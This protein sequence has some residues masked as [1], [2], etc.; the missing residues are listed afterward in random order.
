MHVE[1]LAE[2][3][4]RHR[5][6]QTQLR[7]VGIVD[8]QRVHELQAR[9][10][11]R[12]VI[13][14]ACTTGQQHGVGEVARR[15]TL[16]L[17]RNNHSMRSNANSSPANVSV[18]WR[19]PWPPHQHRL[20]CSPQAIVRHLLARRLACSVAGSTKSS[21]QTCRGRLSRSSAVGLI[22]GPQRGAIARHVSRSTCRLFVDRAVT[23]S[24]RTCTFA[25]VR[26]LHHRATQVVEERNVAACLEIRTERF[27]DC[28]I[29]FYRRGLEPEPTVQ[30]RFVT[31]VA[32]MSRARDWIPNGG[33]SAHAT[34][35]SSAT[36]K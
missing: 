17:S 34:A 3:G 5:G 14:A 36:P 22:T 11:H 31:A 15:D 27:E 21:S 32:K 12:R 16:A 1:A 29:A 6:Q 2:P 9:R 10:V 24:A 20:G 8:H 26:G 35:A 18:S 19:G 28:G 23:N 7:L 25:P 13:A 30:Q 4:G 33:Q